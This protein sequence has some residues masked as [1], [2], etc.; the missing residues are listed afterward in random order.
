MARH[1]VPALPTLHGPFTGET[2][3]IDGFMGPQ[4]PFASCPLSRGASPWERPGEGY[5]LR[6][7]SYLYFD[8]R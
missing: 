2:H 8:F 7:C 5:W 4:A 3:E 6:S 1:D